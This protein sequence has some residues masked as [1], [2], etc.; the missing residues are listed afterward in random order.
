MVEGHGPGFNRN[1]YGASAEIFKKAKDLT[2]LQMPMVASSKIWLCICDLVLRQ[3]PRLTNLKRIYH[4]AARVPPTHAALDT[5]LA[6]HANEFPTSI[7]TAGAL[8]AAIGIDPYSALL[9]AL[10]G[11]FDA[12]DVAHA[13]SAKKGSWI[14]KI[15]NLYE[16]KRK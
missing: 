11:E 12:A 9:P 1:T 6:R 5:V 2:P 15:G 4:F 3:E 7:A 10:T 8:F 16:L 13:G 14:P